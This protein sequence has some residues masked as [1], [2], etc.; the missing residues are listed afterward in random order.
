MVLFP[1][2]SFFPPPSQ[3]EGGGWK[4]KRKIFSLL[5][6]LTLGKEGLLLLLLLFF[7]SLFFSPSPPLSPFPSSFSIL[8]L[9][10]RGRIKVGEVL[11]F[12]SSLPP[13]FQ[14]KRKTYLFKKKKE[15]MKGDFQKRGIER[16]FF[17]KEERRKS[18]ERE[19]M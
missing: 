18:K 6:L 2:P 11:I 14:K 12:I 15:N 10:W 7:F 17:Q 16:Y 3:R 9:L 4:I 13:S 5:F 19:N 8:P 1:S